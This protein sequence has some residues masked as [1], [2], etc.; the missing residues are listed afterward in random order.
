MKKRVGIIID[1][2]KVSKQISDLIALSKTSRNYEIKALVI[3]KVEQKKD[4]IALQIFL[5]SKKRPTKIFIQ[6]NF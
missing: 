6:R 5:T 2:T 4:N 3:N 1:S